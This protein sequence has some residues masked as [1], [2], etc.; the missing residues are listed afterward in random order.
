MIKEKETTKIEGK[1]NW[2]NEIKIQTIME[3]TNASMEKKEEKKTG[4]SKLK[5]KDEYKQ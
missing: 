1:K 5:K 4:K 2:A 3:S